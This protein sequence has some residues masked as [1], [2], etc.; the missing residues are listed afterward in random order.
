MMVWKPL[1]FRRT[2][3]LV[4][5]VLAL[6]VTKRS[7]VPTYGQSVCGPTVSPIVCENTNP[8]NPQ[9]EWDISGSGDPNIQGFA[10]DISVLPGQTQQF[11]VDTNASSF[12]VDIYRLGYY[13]GMGA[14]KVAGPI[15][16]I[17]KNQ[18]NCL[19][20]TPSGLVDCGNW[21]VSASWA[22]PATAVSGI[23]IAKLTANTGGASHIPFV[24]REDTTPSAHHSDLV[25]QTSDTTWQA[26]NRYGGNS[27]YAGGP[28]I[29]PGRAYKVSYNRPITTR[30]DT[31]GQ[32]SVFN[33][34]YP[35]VRFLEANGY[36]VSY[37]SGVD[38]DRAGTT[39]MLHKV[40]MSVGHDEYWS[41]QQR[42]NVEAARN[43]GVHLA[44]F[45]GN[46][47]FWKTRWEN[48][49]DGSGT[50]Y[51]TLVCYKETHNNGPLD[52]SDPPI[53]TGTWG[54]PR[55]SPPG[56]GGRPQN[57]VTGQ[58]FGVNDGDDAAITI[59]AAMGKH[60]FWR[61][62]TVATLSAGQTATMPASTLGYEWD[63][64]VDNGFQPPRLMHLSSTTR[65]VAGKL[66][67]YGS[68]FGSGSVTH[69]LSLYRHSSGAL[70][71]G[72]GTVQWSWGLDS[73]HDRGSAA[74]DVRMKQATVNLFAD[75]GVQ[76]ATIQTGL[77]TTPASSDATAP[78]ST[79]TSPANGASINAG[80]LVTI[81][82]TAVENG[83]GLVMGVEV[84]TDG[85]TTWKA[86][87]GTTSWTYSWTA[88]G[89]G[90][91]NLRSRSFDDTGNLETPSAGVNVTVN[92][93]AGGCPC[94]IWAS[95][96]VPPAP[97]DDGDPLSVEL[98]T[99]FR[100][101]SDGYIT[102]VRFYK[103]AA[104]T[105]THTG[106]L[107]T[108]SGTLLG[109]ATFA[110]ETASG[111]QQALFPN[112]IPITANTTYVISYH[113]PNGH[114]T[115]TDSFFVGAGV[116]NPPLHALRS[117]VDGSNGVYTYGATPAFPTST[118]QGENYWVDVVFSLVPPPDSTPPTVTAV[119]PAAGATQVD[120]A[121]PV[122][123]TFSEPMSA[124]SIFASA[125]GEGG[126]A[127]PGTFE[128]RDSANNVINAT[129]TYNATNRTAT[130]TPKASLAL[131]TTFTALVRGGSVDPRVKDVAGNALA[132]N[133]TWSFTTAA[134]PPPPPSCPCTIW[135]ASALPSPADDF[136]N[137]AVEV[138]TKFRSDL[139]GYITGAR[140]YK[141]S[142]NTGTHT[143]NL[144]TSAGVKLASAQFSGE[145]ASGWQQ[146]SFPTPVQ[147]AAN[148]TYVI[149]YGAPN[150]HYSAP[151]NYFKTNGVDNPPLHGLK[152]GVDG[153]NGIYAYG[154]GTFPTNTYL[155]E[156]YFVDVVFNTTSGPDVSPPRANSVSP[157]AGASGVRTTTQ[158]TATF[159]EPLDASTMNTSKFFLRTPS[160]TVVPA[161]V[162]YNAATLTATL[163]PNAALA[164]TTVYTAVL[165]AGIKDTLGNATTA[166]YTWPFTTSAPPPPPPT[167]GPGGPILVVTTT[168]NQF[169]TYLAEI[170]R[171]EG[172]NE[173][174]TA[175]LSAVTAATLANYDIVLLGETPLTAA[176]VSMF[177]TW[178]NGGGNLIAMRPDKQLAGFIGLTDAGTTLGDAYLLVTNSGPGTGIVNQTIQF[179]GVADRYTLNGATSL[180]ML[181][182]NATT[183]T[184]NP[185]VVRKVSGQGTVV[186]FTF[187][188]AKS[189][190]YT[191]QGNPAWNAQERDGQQ[192]IRSD[193]L[194]FGGTS[195]N[196]VDFAKIQI[197][198]ADEQQR[199]L[200][201]IMLDVNASKKP[202]PR[203]WYFPR[204]LP[205]VVVMTGDDHAANGTQPRFD[206]Y[207]T[208]S[209][210][211]CSVVDWTCIRGTSYVYPNT[212]I[213]DADVATYTGL[214]F[215]IALHVN[216]N[217]A[218][219]TPTTLAN[220]YQTQLTQFG[221]AYPH[222]GNP[223]TN[224]T[225]CIAWSDW[226]T[227]ADV[228]LNN[229][230]R[231]D[232]TYYYWPD[233]WIL[234]RPGMFT[235]S[236]MP[237]RFAKLNGQMIDVYQATTQMT[238]E[239][240]QTWPK[241]I[242]TLLDNA[243]GALGYYGAFVANMHTDSVSP[244]FAGEIGSNA[245]V[246]S[247]KARNIPIITAK[248]LLEWLDG[249]NGSAFQSIAWDGTVL[250]FNIAVGVGANN[251]QALVPA[252]AGSRPITGVLKGG[253]PVT[254]TTQTIKGVQYAIF[255]AA[256]GSYQISYG[257]DIAPPQISSVSAT[258]S[259]NSATITWI[260]NEVSDS[261]VTYGTTPTSLTQTASNATALTSHSIV[262]NGLSANTTY[263]YRVTS[264]DASSNSATSPAPPATP[265][266][267]TTTALSISGAITPSG[268]GSGATINVAGPLSPVT[269][270]DGT[271]NY[272]VGGLSSGTYTVTP[273]KT[274]YTFTPPN[275]SVTLTS[276][277]ATGVNFTA[278][279]VV[280][281]GSITPIAIGSGATVTLTGGPGGT[282]TA[283][284][285]G[286]F[287]FSALPNGN[288]TVTPSKN[289]F[290]FTPASQS[291]TITGGVSVTGVSFTGQ[292]VPT[293][294]ISGTVSGGGSGVTVALSGSS[295]GSVAADPATGAY[296]F[297]G[298]QNGNYTV[299]PS[300][301]G[302]TMSPPSRAVTVNGANM[303][304]I[305]FAAAPI[306][307]F[308]VSGTITPLP[309]GAGVT[310]ALS[311]AGT[312]ST[313]TD[314]SGNYTFA[315][316]LNGSYTV[317]PTKT[318]ATMSPAS[319]PVTVAGAN[320]TAVDFTATAVTSPIRDA[321]VSLGRSNNATT[322]VSPAFSTTAANELLLA[323]VAADNR[324]SS[325][326]TVTNV[327][328]GSLTW[329]LVRRTNTQRGTAE[330]W[331][332]FA[333]S[334]LTNA[335]VTATLSQSVAG[336]IT[337]MSFK[338][339]D[340]SGTNG[341]GAI[342]ATGSGNSSAG[343]PT[344]SL[345]TTRANSIVIGIGD[346][347]D[348]ATSR[349]PGAN[350]T[351]VTQ[352]LASV[353]DTFWVQQIT[354]P[355]AAVGTV[356]TINDTAPTGD[357]YNLT[358]CEILGGS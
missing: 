18:A 272:S 194:F 280:I 282:V 189:I 260:T 357:R 221:A 114:Y 180:A 236:G 67:D 153:P 13:N 146:V 304:G 317:T 202:L 269:A 353:G 201:N 263:Y 211:N 186:A 219:Y 230:I 233:T 20:N 273:S 275:A 329:V 292:A 228:E 262:I 152:D 347:W 187:D 84:S 326:T 125:A 40:Y 220:F 145:S 115:G 335:T 90:T 60:R 123:V 141:N 354:N 69:T 191:R 190:I 257:A 105:G 1:Q 313:T 138:G 170:L 222:A 209:P 113:S 215:E 76:P 197:P 238:D 103:A 337:V 346:D 284:S 110:N 127:A 150:G 321:L 342:G 100:A 270:A 47:M 203:F 97:V 305:D 332:A 331:R 27:L 149:S 286:N 319:R 29:N 5:A 79:I 249:R 341:S 294:T 35:M 135:P 9:S 247:A 61:G 300:K 188:L 26:Y 147:I 64:D 121:A 6:F 268:F 307:T 323:F 210:A 3:L 53:W 301:A 351:V 28:G 231:L 208:A 315:G 126:G 276:T 151:D 245:I 311:G 68:S 349:T 30:E 154:V 58:M 176:Q 279:A 278:Q 199:F 290:T 355:V 352:Y 116:D 216:T 132:A 52:P 99:R 316:L 101:D 195:P 289:G 310:V 287:T 343:A 224:R 96:V 89:S 73:N 240:G 155:S 10:T 324:T 339:V 207:I 117:G 36:D 106:S 32:D 306:P 14:R 356:A 42:A 167:Q 23:Y 171:T 70:V 51:R 109:Q 45:S 4:A 358:I 285:S 333:P 234:D 82:G 246:N 250:S 163:V 198:Q 124:S 136:D 274:G 237:Q 55:W 256:A 299:T 235:G 205:A 173:F 181:Y 327:T 206:E 253:A 92:G 309:L 314:P 348:N 223:V 63:I 254:F 172:A 214:G 94:T 161:T 8:G 43:A 265:S 98:G 266:A 54:D 134:A 255:S 119:F 11:K 293:W 104:N 57:A 157:I 281:S 102:G 156:G 91:V 7:E 162:T 320:V 118:Y 178:V 217:C 56:D 19:T 39:L 62:T 77:V 350:Q 24:V 87:S 81:S 25:F 241:N 65:N 2:L 239:S 168:A 21:T 218:D 340:T 139:P 93:G 143:A 328:G 244:S 196:W 142:A 308:S 59:P 225:H 111:W 86:A 291:V 131:S 158:V 50:P 334:T 227:Q 175:D 267:L 204:M 148:T 140:F 185:A 344:A 213:S 164:Y 295:T 46:E 137:S 120:P 159:N 122:T 88:A 258:P 242:D 243:R 248:Q 200:W 16:G 296:S 33:A 322:V 182:S 192:P 49:I 226:T 336:F 108:T 177:T 15:A 338:G 312:A 277:S 31:N 179:H 259:A 78:T 34:E 283:D 252:N 44:F 264:T 17:P 303:P 144:W 232:T 107:W 12:T 72:A 297:T 41:G 318:G 80:T 174:A 129:V 130:L 37:M 75:M 165:A 183:A 95:S 212:P 184:T 38:T 71:F 112:A 271:G 288:Y 85:G 128:L 229:G 74:A 66:L 345:V 261:T 251:L 83:G 133:N 302:F 166:D 193:D 298:L 160:N 325:A 330:I 169:S 48:S 22:V